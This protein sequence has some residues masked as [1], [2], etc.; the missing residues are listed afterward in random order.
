MP[1]DLANL[2]ACLDLRDEGAQR[3]VGENYRVDYE[4]LF[5]GQVAAQSIMALRSVVAAPGG[6][7]L[8]SFNQHF[9]RPGNPAVPVTYDV[10]VQHDGRTFAAA[11]V[12]A[13]Q[14][15]K[16]VG[17]MS[18]S[19]HRPELGLQL[20]AT[21]PRLPDPQ[22]GT[23]VEMALLPWEVRMVDDADL[24]ARGSRPARLRFWMRVPTP[25]NDEDRWTAHALVAHA[26]D[27]TAVGTALLPVEGLSQADLGSAIETSVTSQSMWFHQPFRA[28]QWLLVDQEAPVISEGRAFGRADIW[29][30]SGRLV[31]SMAQESVVRSK[32][33]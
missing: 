16:L 33:P 3:F 30:A 19:L 1:F 25:G 27:L 23:A 28:D 15:G 8:K 9:V 20:Q 21:T 4:R 7:L 5:G 22:A 14:Q 11:G 24:Y 32:L 17:L 29:T 13:T 2:L 10:D 18:A 26:T 31:A 12:R 6:K